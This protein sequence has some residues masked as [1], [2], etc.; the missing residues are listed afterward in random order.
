MSVTREQC[1][2]VACHVKGEKCLRVSFDSGFKRW[3]RSL[4]SSC[5]LLPDSSRRTS[6]D[7]L[8]V[9]A[10]RSS[11]WHWPGSVKLDELLW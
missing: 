8:R 5:L 3:G 6:Q 7:C 2:G 11:P 4:L 1:S 10:G 9:L